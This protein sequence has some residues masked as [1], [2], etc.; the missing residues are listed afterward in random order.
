MNF[1]M[2]LKQQLTAEKFDNFHSLMGITLTRKT[3]ILN[4]PQRMKLDEISKLVSILNNPD[5][6]LNILISEYYCGRNVL[7]LS[8]CDTLILK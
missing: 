8:D 3:H 5:I 1:K 2:F 6:T 4:S 7:T